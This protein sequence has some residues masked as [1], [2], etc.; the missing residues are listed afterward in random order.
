MPAI[1]TGTWKSGE[2]NMEARRAVIVGVHAHADGTKA[3]Q[4][5]HIHPSII[6]VQLLHCR[7]QKS[8]PS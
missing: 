2:T 1:R 6:L 3:L 5:R 4:Y 7:E 8:S